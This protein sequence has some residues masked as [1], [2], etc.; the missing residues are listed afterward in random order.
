MNKRE[1]QAWLGSGFQGN[2]EMNLGIKRGTNWSLELLELDGWRRQSGTWIQWYEILDTKYMG[3][4][5]A[6]LSAHVCIIT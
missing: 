4:G 1:H 2:D 3:P 5:W 6:F